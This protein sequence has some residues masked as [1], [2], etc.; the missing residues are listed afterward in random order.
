[1]ERRSIYADV[2][3]F[4]AGLTNSLSLLNMGV[5]TTHLTGALTNAGVSLGSIDFVSFALYIGVFASFI[6]GSILAAA[7][8]AKKSFT[9]ASLITA[10]LLII[11]GL[12]MPAQIQKRSADQLLFSF[13][14][15]TT[16]GAQNASTGLTPI[17][18]TTHITGA[19][20]DFGA[21]I[22]KKDLKN[23]V[24]L[25]LFLLCF[26]IGILTAFYLQTIVGPRGF[27]VAGACLA[28]AVLVQRNY[29]AF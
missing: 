6:I 18:R 20:T 28:A 27:I 5:F 16:M 25:G 1:M 21:A 15:A 14:A 4:V 2:F 26:M 23:T 24:R 13:L 7:L 29:R 22:A 8:M 11:V 19:S 3:G 10:A 9:Y 17:G 12:F